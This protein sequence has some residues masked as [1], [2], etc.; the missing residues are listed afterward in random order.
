MI[1]YTN[2]NI[3]EIKANYCSETRKEL[4]LG[5]LLEG[6]Q[7]NILNHVHKPYPFRL[8]IAAWACVLFFQ[9]ELAL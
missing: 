4:H 8:V 1:S 6:S 9:L 3:H 2:G 7:C 5:N